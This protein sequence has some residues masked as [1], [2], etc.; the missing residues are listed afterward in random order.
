VSPGGSNIP[1]VAVLALNPT[2]PNQLAYRIGHH[3]RPQKPQSLNPPHPL[4]SSRCYL[5]G[6]VPIRAHRTPR[7]PPWVSAALSPHHEL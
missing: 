3:F 5:T 7:L 1:V 6:S 2:A 4:H